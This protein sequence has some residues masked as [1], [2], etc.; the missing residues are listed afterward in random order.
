MILVVSCSCEWS[1]SKLSLVKLKLRS[2][3]LVSINS[4]M[5]LTIKQEIAINLN[6]EDIIDDF[7][8]CIQ[9]RMVL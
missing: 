8:N 4:L 7:Q 5:L 3:M 1:I 9:H 6:L 2:I